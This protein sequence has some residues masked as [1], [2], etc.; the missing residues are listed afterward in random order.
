MSPNKIAA[1]KY[2]EAFTRSDHTAILSLLTDDVVWI[3]PGGFH[4]VG[5]EAFDKEIENNAF[6]GPPDITV[7]R[8]IEE[9]DIVVAEGSVRSTRRDGGVLHAVFCDM[10]VMENAKIKLLTSYVTVLE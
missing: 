9:N 1:A 2:M 4:L 3:M 7:T 10:F 6:V 5:K 8:V